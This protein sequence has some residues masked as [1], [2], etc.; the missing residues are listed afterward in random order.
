M[1]DDNEPIDQETGTV[2]VYRLLPEIGDALLIVNCGTH[3]E[4]R[5]QRVAPVGTLG[6]TEAEIEDIRQGKI[7]WN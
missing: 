1:D 7:V 4:V 5:H 2:N 6:L 3:F